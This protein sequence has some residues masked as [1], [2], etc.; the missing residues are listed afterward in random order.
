MEHQETVLVEGVPNPLKENDWNRREQK[1]RHNK[2][3]A[4]F[5]V[6]RVFILLIL[7]FGAVISFTSQST[8][9]QIGYVSAFSGVVGAL[10]QRF[11]PKS[12]DD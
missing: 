6:D 5:I 9:L 3:W 1:H 2:W 4:N 12:I 7:I 10:I 8:T 11:K